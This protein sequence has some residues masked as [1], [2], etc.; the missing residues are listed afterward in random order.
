MVVVS[1]TPV[2]SKRYIGTE[3]P[4]IDLSC[5]REIVQEEIVNACE[6]YGFFKVINHAIPNDVVAKMEAVGLEFFAKPVTEKQQA[7]PAN[8]LGYGCKSIGP[9]GDTGE[10]EY[11]LLHANQ[12]LPAKIICEENQIEF[13]YIEYSLMNDDDYYVLIKEKGILAEMCVKKER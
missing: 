7:G 12:Q 5:R 11:L 1:T 9:N 13:R 10:V 2:Q 6:E 4:V 3:I 8:P